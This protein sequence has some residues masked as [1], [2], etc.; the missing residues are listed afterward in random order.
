MSRNVKRNWQEGNEEQ[1]TDDVSV[2]KK[3][4]HY[5]NAIAVDYFMFYSI[6]GMYLCDCRSC[7]DHI[8]HVLK[9]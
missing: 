4:G 2:R 3:Y 1:N 5:K 6:G 7:K 8:C 9:P